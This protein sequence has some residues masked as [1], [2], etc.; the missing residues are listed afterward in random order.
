MVHGILH[1]RKP[2]VRV[3]KPE[4]VRKVTWGSVL[5][6]E[7][8]LAGRPANCSEKRPLGKTSPET[9]QKSVEQKSYAQK[10]PGW[11]VLGA[12]IATN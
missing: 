5:R 3:L 10:L 2:I 1:K 4:K 9:H 8:E 6:L 7:A 12:L 11:P